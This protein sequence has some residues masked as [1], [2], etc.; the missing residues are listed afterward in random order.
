M[1]TEKNFSIENRSSNP[2]NSHSKNVL[3]QI[4]VWIDGELKRFENIL[5]LVAKEI[6]IAYLCSISDVS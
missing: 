5:N 2:S 1:K 4:L 6:F 3:N